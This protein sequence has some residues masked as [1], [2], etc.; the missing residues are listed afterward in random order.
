MTSR[1]SYSLLAALTIAMAGPV[2]NYLG[3]AV[4]STATDTGFGHDS[5]H[6]YLPAPSDSV[7]NRSFLDT[8]TVLAETLLPTG[9]AYILRTVMVSDTTRREAV[10]TAYE[11]GDTLLRRRFDFAG[12]SLWANIYR[13]PFVIGSWWP[14]GVAGTYYFDLNGDSLEDTIRIW[15][16]SVKVVGIEDVV[17]PYGL[18]RNCYKLLLVARQSLAMTYEGVPV[19]ETTFIRQHEWYKDSLWRI[20]DSLSLVARAYTRILIWLRT[21]DIFSTTV[22]QL[23]GL[24]LGTTENPA[25]APCAGSLHAKPNPFRNAVTLHLE[26][27]SPTELRI[28]NASGCLVRSLPVSY[29][30]CSLAWDGLDFRGRAA[31]PGVYLARCGIHSCVITRLE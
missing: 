16:D 29:P 1:L 14:T 11:S 9:P 31:P 17:V 3:Y 8:T 28:Y 10:D 2:G 7:L 13:V 21:A 24:H 20:K 23:T 19:R 12:L 25:P 27:D 6:M 26:A 5:I 4:G 22:T 18:V 15:A 30:T